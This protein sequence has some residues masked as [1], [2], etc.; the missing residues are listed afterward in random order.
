MLVLIISF[1]KVIHGNFNSSGGL[2]SA[3]C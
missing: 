2:L 3:K 1:R